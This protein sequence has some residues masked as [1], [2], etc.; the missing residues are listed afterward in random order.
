VGAVVEAPGFVPAF[1]GRKNLSLLAGSVSVP[2]S[3]VDSVLQQVGLADRARDSYGSYSLGMKQRLAIGAALLKSP[4]L[5]ILDEP[6]NGLDPA[7]IR[8]IREMIRELG[9]SGV[10]VLLSSHILAEVQQVC[11]S[12]SIVGDGRLLAS[13]RVDRLLGENV[14]RTRV[15]VSDPQGA[16]HFLESAG[17]TVSRETHHLVV[18]GHEHPGEITKV[19]ALKG[20]YV[21]ELTAIRPTLE[22]FFLKLTGRDGDDAAAAADKRGPSTS[23]EDVS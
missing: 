4:D 13:G 16:K 10:T 1:S 3:S 17:F 23:D 7:G 22:S 5:L 21:Q 19:L 2:R 14:S 11:H 20:I 18:E 8:G 9:E 6:T 12:V 15:G